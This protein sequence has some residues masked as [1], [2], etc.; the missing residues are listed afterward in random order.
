[1]V[2]AARIASSCIG[3]ISAGFTRFMACFRSFR[4]ALIMAWVGR[5]IFLRFLMREDSVTRRSCSASVYRSKLALR[6]LSVAS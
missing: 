5:S 4:S 2:L 3:V 1:M 6:W